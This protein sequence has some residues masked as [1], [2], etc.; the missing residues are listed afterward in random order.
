[1]R[2]AKDRKRIEEL[3]RLFDSE[4]RNELGPVTYAKVIE[5]NRLEPNP[6]VCHSHDY[7]DSNQIMLDTLY[8]LSDPPEE[9]NKPYALADSDDPTFEYW[10]DIIQLAWIRWAKDTG[11]NQGA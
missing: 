3:A 11:A 6:S 7:C 4:L 2:A 9:S 10:T 5:A 1:M 8:L